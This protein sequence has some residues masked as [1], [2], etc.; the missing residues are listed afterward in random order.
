MPG[1]AAPGGRGKDEEK[2]HRARKEL[3]VHERNKIDLVGGLTGRV[4]PVLGADPGPPR[5]DWVD[6]AQ[7]ETPDQR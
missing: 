5:D 3:S 7:S 2:E 1:M 6:A 4:P